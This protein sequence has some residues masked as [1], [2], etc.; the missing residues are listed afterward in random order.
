[1]DWVGGYLGFEGAFYVE[2]QGRSGG[3]CLLWT[4]AEEGTIVGYSKNH[5]NLEIT[6]EGFIR[7]RLTGFYGEPRWHLRRDT[8]RLLRVLASS[9]DLPCV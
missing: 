3:L 6:H 8:W 5:I 2:A 1:M 7:W 9:T 4:H